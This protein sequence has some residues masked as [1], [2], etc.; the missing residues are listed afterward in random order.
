MTELHENIEKNRATA[1]PK[2]K[3]PKN[4]GAV[5]DAAHLI[6]DFNFDCTLVEKVDKKER[7]ESKKTVTFQNMRQSEENIHFD[8][9]CSDE[10]EESSLK[11]KV[12]LAVSII[13]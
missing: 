10:S 11:E 5:F 7:F 1:P 4:F 2:R 6:S 13:D 9:V 3:A 8:T 12:K